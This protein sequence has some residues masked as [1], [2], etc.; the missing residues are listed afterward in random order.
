MTRVAFWFSALLSGPLAI[1]ACSSEPHEQPGAP[2]AGPDGNGAPETSTVEPEVEAGTPADA[3]KEKPPFDPSD[4]AVKCT[5]SPCAVELVAGMRHFCARM[6]DGTLRC[7]GDNAKGALGVVDPGAS[8]TLV[9]HGAPWSVPV[10]TDLEGVT[11]VVASGTTTCAISGGGEVRCWGGNQ[12][13]QLALDPEFPINDED[14]HPTPSLVAL[15]SGAKHIALGPTSACALLDGDEV[16]CWGDNTTK[17]LARP[18]STW[19]EAPGSADL[20]GLAVARLALGSFTGFVVTTTGELVSWGA[21]AGAE[22]SVSGRETSLS[23]SSDPV[24][25]G[26]APVSSFSVSMT[27]LHR[28]SSSAPLGAPLPALQGIGHA[29]AVVKGDLFC[30][31]DTLRGALGAGP[32]TTSIL[33][34]RIVVTSETGWPQQVAAAQELTC[35]RMTDGTV[36]CTGDNAFGA[37]GRDPKIILS[38]GFEPTEALPGRA[39]AVAASD[40]SVCALLAGGQVAC[41]GSNQKGELGQGYRDHLAHPTPVL[42]RF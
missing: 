40:Q 8:G 32:A 14:R 22:G 13:A 23:P 24:A 11:Q 19:I 1:V 7:W 12:M 5:G 37:L 33:P 6:N 35:V 29:C 26:L 17:Q 27:F 16:W 2:D 15:P 3:A 30:W 20:D 18:A 41:W 9:D 39:V 10:V 38:T 25:I 34:R 31:G 36:Q 28:P 4:E 21:V 42:V